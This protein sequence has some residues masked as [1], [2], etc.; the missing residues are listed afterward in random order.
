M[1]RSREN[2]KKR[3]PDKKAGITYTKNRIVTKLSES[4]KFALITYKN[5]EKKNRVSKVLKMPLLIE[6][7]WMSLCV[8]RKNL[9]SQS[10]PR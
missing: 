8:P 6:V 9:V 7:L 5:G 2:A 4:I 10:R 3:K 1:K